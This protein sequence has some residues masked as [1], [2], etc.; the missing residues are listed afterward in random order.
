MAVRPGHDSDSFFSSEKVL[1]LYEVHLVGTLVHRSRCCLEHR[2]G[3]L[4]VKPSD[5]RARWV[6][7]RHRARSRAF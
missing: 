1:S 6:S 5:F 3:Q 2:P 7:P 4:L